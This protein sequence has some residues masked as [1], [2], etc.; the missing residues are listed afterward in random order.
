MNTITH[1]F[2]VAG[3]RTPTQSERIWRAIKDNPGIT[4]ARAATATGIKHNNA[5]SLASAMVDRGMLIQNSQQLRVKGPRG[6]WI[7]R[8]VA[9]YTV[10]PRMDGKYELLPP[11]VKPKAAVITRAPE[12]EKSQYSDVVSGGGMDPRRDAQVAKPTTSIDHLTLGEAR[13]LYD[14]LHQL[15]GARG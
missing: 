11:P 4:A 13:S 6:S 7:V 10:D 9:T 8:K 12:P 1:A 15:F 5:S 2:K 3:V 14:A